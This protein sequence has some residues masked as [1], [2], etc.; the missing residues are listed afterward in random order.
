MLQFE[1]LEGLSD[2]TS[3]SE[4]WKRIH[5]SQRGG[6]DGSDATSSREWAEAILDSL[7]GADGVQTLVV[8]RESEV[9]AIVPVFLKRTRMMPTPRNDLSAITEL[10]AGRTALLV[11]DNDVETLEY[12][13]QTLVSEVPGWDLL[14]LTLPASSSAYG[15]FLSA[16]NRCDLATE[17]IGRSESPY[18]S[19]GSSWETMLRNLPKKMRWTIKKSEKDLNALGNLVYERPDE[20]ERTDYLKECM[21]GVERRSWKEKAGTSITAN[22][23]Q[24][25]FFSALIDRV[26][27]SRALS[28][29]ILT[30]NEKPI[31][32]IVGLAVGDGVFLDLKESF[33]AA[34]GKHSPGHVLKRYAMQALIDDGVHTYDFMGRC[35]AYKMKWT[36]QTYESVTLGVYNRGFRSSFFR[37]RS[38]VRRLVR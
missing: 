31:A 30:L 27:A 32:Y 37:A 36:K 2:F 1:I 22:S 24:Q 28:A 17:E 34:Y 19:L 26:S 18:I 23:D 25:R 20:P 21:F 16:V 12:V 29:H 8:R 4:E 9:V 6:I 3:L 38:A 33:D 10:H 15:A 5:V 35:E 13:L 14:I 11:L 7:I